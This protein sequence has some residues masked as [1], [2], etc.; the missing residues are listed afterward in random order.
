M[1]ATRSRTNFE[2]RQGRDAVMPFSE[3]SD[4]LMSDDGSVGQISEEYYTTEETL[5]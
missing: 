5:I 2:V 3:N 4:V 1:T